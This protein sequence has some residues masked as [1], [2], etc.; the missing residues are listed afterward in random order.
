MAA[1]CR[2]FPGTSCGRLRRSGYAASSPPSSFEG[3]LLH[4]LQGVVVETWNLN[5]QGVGHAVGY[6]FHVALEVGDLARRLGVRDLDDD[7]GIPDFRVW[8]YV[9]WHRVVTSCIAIVRLAA[10]TPRFAIV[11]LVIFR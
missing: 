8:T 6:L 7:V 5:H 10:V 9:D 2:T 1:I 11:R 4:P 3:A